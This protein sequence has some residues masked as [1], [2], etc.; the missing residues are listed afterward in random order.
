MLDMPVAQL[1]YVDPHIRAM[2]TRHN[3]LHGSGPFL[4][5]D[6]IPLI[7]SAYRGLLGC[8]TAGP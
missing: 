6:Q 4:V 2:A 1:A 5:A 7:R 3:A 8:Q